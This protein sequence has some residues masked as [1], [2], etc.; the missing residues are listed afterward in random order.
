MVATLGPANDGNPRSWLATFSTRY[1]NG[2]KDRRGRLRVR[3]WQYW[4][5]NKLEILAGYLPAFN[6]AAKDR[7]SERLYIDLMAGQPTNRE[8]ITGERVR[9]LCATGTVGQPA[10]H[11]AFCEMLDNATALNAVDDL[12]ILS[13]EG[14]RLSQFC[15]WPD[16][17]ITSLPGG[18][19]RE[20]GFRRFP[21][22]ACR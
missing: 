17:V 6:T 4:T 11:S 3:E 16:G 7:S 21:A 9:W 1:D 15:G 12:G 13:S 2:D 18:L 20:Q 8:K 10:V 14:S 19:R 5:R 22:R